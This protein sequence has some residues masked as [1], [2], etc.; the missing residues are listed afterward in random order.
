M[1]I[2]TL[3]GSPPP[4]RLTMPSAETIATGQTWVDYDSD[5]DSFIIYFAARPV[6]GVHYDIGTHVTAIANP[7]TGQVLGIQIEAWE[8]QFVPQ[9]ADLHRVWPEFKSTL[10]PD[11]GWSYTLR[12]LGVFVLFLLAILHRDESRL[13]PQPA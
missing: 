5:S 7:A 3:L 11:Q 12:T 10:A 2:A 4:V 1:D 6:P 8:R 9:Y 13:T